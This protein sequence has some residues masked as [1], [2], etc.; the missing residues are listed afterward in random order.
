M[1]GVVF[2]EFFAFIETQFGLPM[3]DQLLAST[4]PESGGSYAALETYDFDEM[5]AML[6]ELGARSETPVPNLIRAF[7]SH[8]FNHFVEGHSD[9]LADVHSTEE[10]LSQVE[11]RIHVDVRKLFPDAELPTIG[12]AQLTP[13]QSEVT[14]YSARPFADL[15]EGLILA[16]IDHFGDPIDLSREDLP[17]CDSTQARFLLTRR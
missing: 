9:S 16:A 10:L 1:K 3:V 4:D 13:N 5:M 15:A 14:Y 8:L 17:P 7:G 11:N 2:T 12:F 6:V